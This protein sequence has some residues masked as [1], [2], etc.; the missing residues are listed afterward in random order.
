V[1]ERTGSADADR[2]DQLTTAPKATDDDAAPRIDVTTTDDGNTRIDIRDDA[3]V[4]PGS[5]PEDR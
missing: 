4:R 5:E 3:E 2:E 1:T